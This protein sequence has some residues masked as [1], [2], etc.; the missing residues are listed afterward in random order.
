METLTLSLASWDGLHGLENPE[1][2][3]YYK[4]AYHFMRMAMEDEAGAQDFEAFLGTHWFRRALALMVQDNESPW[5]NNV[6]TPEEE[7]QTDII[8]N[9]FIL[10]YTELVEQLGE[11]YSDWKWGVVRHLRPEHPMGKVWP[12]GLMFNCGPRAI[13]GGDETLNHSG[14]RFSGSG[15]YE[16]TGGPQMRIVHDLE[17]PEN[18]WSILPGGQSGH[19]FSRH[20]DDQF[21]DYCNN[22]FRVRAMPPTIPSA[23]PEILYFIP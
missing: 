14:F 10:T 3:V 6:N 7:S 5:W 8:T 23:W 15:F 4:W 2:V 19:P 22:Q 17:N 21:N 18:S 16:I 1:P 9:S 20:Y 12:L 13:G 11:D